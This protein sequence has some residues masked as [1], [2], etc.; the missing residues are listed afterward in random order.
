MSSNSAMSSNS[1]QLY[2]TGPSSFAPV[3]TLTMAEFAA[4]EPALR[5]QALA[6]LGFE[7]AHRSDGRMVIGGVRVGRRN[8]A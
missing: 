3:R 8:A 1:R 7:M 2:P 5:K 4:L 6:E